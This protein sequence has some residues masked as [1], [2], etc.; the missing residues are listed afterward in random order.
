MSQALSEI[1]LLEDVS[2]LPSNMQKVYLQ[3]VSAIDHSLQKL[4][5][6]G[7]GPH[8]IGEE[9]I[10]SMVTRLLNQELTQAQL[11][12]CVA[13]ELQRQILMTADLSAVC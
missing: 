13:Q 8:H 3:L 11:E 9:F 1:A 5:N 6:N 12:D 7:A 10:E 2:S 4:I